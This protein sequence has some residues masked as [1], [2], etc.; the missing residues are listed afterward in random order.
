MTM[1]EQML[2][3]SASGIY[4]DLVRKFRDEGHN[5]YVMLPFERR[6]DRKTMLYSEEGIHFLGVKTLNVVKTNVVEK[7]FGQML[8]EG[9]FKAAFRRYLS[10]VTFHLILYSTPPITFTK[11]IDYA[12]SLN[13]HAIAYLMLKDIFPQN[14]VDVGMISKT[15]VR[16]L[17]Y[18]FFRNKE[19]ELYKVSDYIGCM[20]PANVKFLL[21][22]N[23]EIDRQKVE[24][25]VNSYNQINVVN[26]SDDKKTKIRQKYNLPL[27]KPIFIYGGNLGKPQGISFMIECLKENRYRNDCFFVVVGNGTEYSR[28][29]DWMEREKPQNVRL[30]QRLPKEDYDCLTDAC[31]VGLIFLDYRFTIPNFPSRL[32]PYLMTKKPILVCTDKNCD[33]GPIAVENGFGIWAPSNSTDAFTKA[34]NTM[35]TANMKLMGE[36]G[37]MFYLSN[38]TV[39]HT[40]DAI[41]KHVK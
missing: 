31:D 12:K 41:I 14:A 16:G 34:L 29:N 8:L 11:V 37:Y 15:G 10:D 26:M 6:L 2:T 36:K 5:V 40:Y 18:K 9:Q 7:G 38:Y 3:I 13:P 21:D 35:L 25:C 33:M 27:S 23:P 22:H 30:F 4:T 1:S 32:L 19:K 20:S 24:I 17:L 28:V 39:Q